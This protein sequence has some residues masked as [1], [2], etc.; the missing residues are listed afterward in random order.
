M[1]DKDKTQKTLLAYNDVFADIINA[2]VFAG[3]P[4]VKPEDL[5]DA[6]PKSMYKMD[7]RAHELE[8]DSAKFW[9]KSGVTFALYGLENQSAP[10][11]DMSL[12]MAA[13]DALSYRSQLND[14][15]PGDDKKRY[16]VISL[17]L[18][19]GYKK[20]WDKPKQ[21]SERTNVSEPLKRF[22]ND[23]RINL[24][25]LAFLEEREASL[26]KSDFRFVI[27]YLRQMR[28]SGSYYPSEPDAKLEHV[29]EILQLMSAMTG[30]NRFEDAVNEAEGGEY[31]MCEFIDMLEEKGRAEKEKE[32]IISMYQDKLPTEQIARI[33][34]KSLAEVTAS[35]RT[36]GFVL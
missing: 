29:H 32:L 25:E 12:R 8:R 23:Y 7:G 4:V 28:Q 6:L 31:T 1:G 13:Y 10:D 9:Q 3:E 14:D 24:F 21:L 34:K 20:H 22:F 17:V 11:E 16:P 5:S 26:F 33:V 36:A 15:K 18:Y 19:Y 27:D 2:F 30:D 35:L